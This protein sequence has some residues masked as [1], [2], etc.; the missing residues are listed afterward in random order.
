MVAFASIKLH[1]LVYNLTR[2]C[3]ENKTPLCHL[4]R[5]SLKRANLCNFYYLSTLFFCFW[6]LVTMPNCR[7]H[8]ATK[9]IG[10]KLPCCCPCSFLPNKELP[11]ADQMISVF[12]VFSLGKRRDRDK[13]RQV[14]ALFSVIQLK[15]SNVYFRCLQRC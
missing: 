15:K 9:K 3:H 7:W 5:Q 1:F 8:Q 10:M 11:D 2:G 4:F 14:L 13:E 12:F 6:L